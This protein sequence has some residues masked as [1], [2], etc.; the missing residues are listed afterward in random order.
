ME[1]VKHSFATKQRIAEFMIERSV[2]A[3][4][5]FTVRAQLLERWHSIFADQDYNREEIEKLQIEMERK[6]SKEALLQFGFQ[7]GDSSGQ[8]NPFLFA[9]PFRTFADRRLFLIGLFETISD[10]PFKSEKKQTR[11]GAKINQT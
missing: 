4:L 3:R 5:K 8:Q 9:S 11:T 1:S 2:Y 7:L 10:N 6:T